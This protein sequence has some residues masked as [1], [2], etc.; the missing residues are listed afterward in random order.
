MGGGHRLKRS[1]FE[2]GLELNPQRKLPNTVASGVTGA[3]FGNHSKA[4]VS[5]IIRRI[6]EIYVVGEIG[7]AAFEFEHDSLSDPEVLGEPQGEVNCLGA[8]ERPHGSV[9][10]AANNV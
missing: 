10:K 7:K 6:V 5:Q 8:N 2:L 4:G 1:R 9:A 3:R